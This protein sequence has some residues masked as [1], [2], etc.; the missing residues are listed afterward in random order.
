M[1]IYNKSYVCIRWKYTWFWGYRLISGR[2]TL[3]CSVFVDEKEEKKNSEKFPDNL[4]YFINAY[5][6]NLPP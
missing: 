3:D 1:S 4:I 6:L 5:R 2:V